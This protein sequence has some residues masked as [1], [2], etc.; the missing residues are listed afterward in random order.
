MSTAWIPPRTCWP[1]ARTRPAG[2]DLASLYRQRMAELDLPRQYRSIFL[3]GPTF[4]L[5]PDD[6]TAAR[7]LHG[8]GR[9]LAPG[10]SALV[11]GGS[12]LVPLFVPAPTPPEQLGS[13]TESTTSDGS[14]IRV[15][16]VSV[17][18][19]EDA[20]IQQTVLRY[21]KHTG[22]SS[23]VEDRPWLLHWHT[24]GGFG[25]LAEA[26]GLT[27]TGIR[28]HQG[29]TASAAANEFTFVLQRDDRSAAVS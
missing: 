25:E 2:R 16:A 21:E 13:V 11:P 27:V 19:D 29:R 23:I 7:A 26:A 12:A 20:R 6:A 9:H 28:D 17:E 3:A 18:R 5:L 1:V 22:T 4:T 24:Q 15:R 10:G 8:I 14:R